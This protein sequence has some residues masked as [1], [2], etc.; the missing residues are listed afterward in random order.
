MLEGARADEISKPVKS[1]IA[2]G[3]AYGEKNAAAFNQSIADYKGWLQSNFPKAVEK[4]RAE[5]YYND[6]KAFLHAMIIYICAFVLSGFAL[7]TLQMLPGVSETLR[8]SALYIIILAGIVHTFGLVF[9]MVLEGRPP[10]T[11]LY[12]SAIFIGWGAMVLGIILERIYKLGIGNIVASLAGFIT[13]LHR[14][15]PRHWAVIRWKCC[16]RCW[17]RISG[18]PRTLSW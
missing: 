10:V 4:G 9:R 2:M 3:V 7:V 17:I 13:L 8:R 15:Q 11:N 1:L 5:F 16:A 18:W 6:V 14:P 12:S